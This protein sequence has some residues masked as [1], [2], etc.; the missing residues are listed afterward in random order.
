M[1]ALCSGEP[2]CSQ[3]FWDYMALPT[4]ITSCTNIRAHTHTFKPSLFI[5]L[6]LNKW[7]KK[8]VGSAYN[9]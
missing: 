2:L 1:L 5:L 6:N 4:S 8:M 9:E 3:A 7:I